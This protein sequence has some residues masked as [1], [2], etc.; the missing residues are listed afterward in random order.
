MG[1]NSW[2]HFACNI[3]EKII[4]GA[5]D[6]LVQTGMKDLG[7]EFVNIDD[8]WQSPQRDSQ[9]NLQ[10]DPSKFPSGMKALADYVHSK[11]LKLGIY[12]DAG[13]KTCQGYPGSWDHEEQDAKIFASWGIDYLKL[14][15][16]DMGLEDPAKVYPRMSLALFNSGRPIVFSMCEWGLWFPWDWAGPIANLWRTDMDISDNFESLLRIVETR[17]LFSLHDQSGP[18]A[19]N[20][21]DMLEVGNGG[22]TTA[23]YK[24]QF[25]LWAIFAAPLI[26][27]NDLGNMSIDTLN[28]LTNQEVIAVDQD[29]LGREGRRVVGDWGIDI[30]MRELVK[31]NIA[32]V[33]FNKLNA[34]Y[35]VTIHWENLQLLP[36]QQMAL[37]DLW[38]HKDIGNFVKSYPVFVEPHSSVMLKMSPVQ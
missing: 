8:C 12:S 4:R 29:L 35:N 19:W 5:A 9:G 1:W 27:G 32:V 23:E 6:L 14:D 37:R 34:G 17:I 21:P 33:V 18:G 3:N 22:M 26:A 20:D 30:W 28:I 38:A 2:N 10:A 25:S 16:C 31:G 13:T 24:S 36:N 7:Y 15:W 11:G